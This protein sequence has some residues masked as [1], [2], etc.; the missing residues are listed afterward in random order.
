MDRPTTKAAWCASRAPA[1]L[2]QAARAPGRGESLQR[3]R[4]RRRRL[5][6]GPRRG[7]QLPRLP[8]ALR[9][10]GHSRPCVTRQYADAVQ[11]Q[12][13]KNPRIYAPFT[14]GEYLNSDWEM[15]RLVPQLAGPHLPPIPQDPAPPSG[16]YPD[17]PTLVLTGEFDSITTP[18]EGALVARR[19]PP[20]SRCSWPTAST[21]RPSATPTSAPYTSSDASSDPHTGLT[22]SRLSCA[23]QVPPL[24]RWPTT[25]AHTARVA[26][27]R[28][29][30][31]R[32][33]G[34]AARLGQRRTDGRRT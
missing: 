2:S 5:Q 7:S 4:G 17:V 29:A 31:K 22:G 11:A 8:A 12:I 33:A 15:A 10:D 16:S 13:K 14:V 21:S 30:R 18:E 19:F 25:T 26:G 9:H 6:R 23:N 34:S 1:G 24:P 3:L 27:S 32:A 28:P 20:P